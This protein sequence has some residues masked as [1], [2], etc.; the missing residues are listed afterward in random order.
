MVGPARAIEAAIGEVPLVVFPLKLRSP[1]SKSSGFENVGF[2]H[3]QRRSLLRP[4]GPG[5][6][7]PGKQEEAIAAAA[8][9]LET[10]PSGQAMMKRAAATTTM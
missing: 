1:A 7:K 8:L 5:Q 2:A 3:Q 4:A 6:S 9:L 10:P